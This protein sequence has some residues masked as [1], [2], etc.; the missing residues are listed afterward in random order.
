MPPKLNGLIYSSVKWKEVF[1]FIL[2]LLIQLRN[3]W[4]SLNDITGY[5]YNNLHRK[6][7]LG[8]LRQA[9]TSIQ[10]LAFLILKLM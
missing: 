5:H 4:E 9:E 3:A 2:E 10:L 1:I 6:S 7:T 8:I